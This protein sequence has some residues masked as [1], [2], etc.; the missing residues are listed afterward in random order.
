MSL[1][2][3]PV[4]VKWGRGIITRRHFCSRP[5]RGLGEEDEFK[6]C[7]IRNVLDTHVEQP[8]PLCMTDPIQVS[9]TDLFPWVSGHHPAQK[10]RDQ[11]LSRASFFLQPWGPLFL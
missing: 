8:L 2:L 3:P 10:T 9:S 5:R 11:R 6:L 4:L 1:K 7:L